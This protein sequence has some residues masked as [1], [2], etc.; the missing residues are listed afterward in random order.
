MHSPYYRPKVYF[1]I[2]ID[3]KPAGRILMELYSDVAPRTVENFR[4]LCKGDTFS[5]HVEGRRLAFAGS[6]FHRVIKNFMIQGGG[7]LNIHTMK[8]QL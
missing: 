7:N 4:V 6:S 8:K 1:D 3:S 5:K 2:T